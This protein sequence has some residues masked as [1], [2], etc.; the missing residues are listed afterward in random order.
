MA[1]KKFDPDDFLDKLREAMFDNALRLLS[2]STRL[3]PDECRE[4]L[5]QR[6]NNVEILFPISEKEGLARQCDDP[7]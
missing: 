4:E 6:V 5:W 1:R 3:I 7:V 2:R